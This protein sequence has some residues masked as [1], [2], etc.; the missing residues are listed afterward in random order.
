MQE[1][2]RFLV[3]HPEVIG[4]L[5]NGTVSLIGLSELEVKAVVKVFSESMEPLGYWK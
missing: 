4:K 1:M 5:Q 3:E 2:I